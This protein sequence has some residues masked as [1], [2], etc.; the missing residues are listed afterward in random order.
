[1]IKLMVIGNL[2]KDAL[3]NT[4]NSKTVLNFSVAHTEKFNDKEKTVW[5][6]CAYW[7]EKTGIAPY[8]KKGQQVY[9]E[10]QP[11]VRT[12]ESNGK[13]GASLQ[14]RVSTVQLIGSKPKEEKQEAQPIK[15]DEEAPF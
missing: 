4:V 6:E 2:G 15:Q 12:W 11:E 9:V 13:S 5:V 7:T 8:L 10:G 14:V 3:V 1:M